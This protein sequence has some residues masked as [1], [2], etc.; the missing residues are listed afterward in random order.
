MLQIQALRQDPQSAKDRLAIKNFI[1]INLVDEIIALD[2]ERKNCNWN[3]IIHYPNLIA[4]QK[5]SGSSWQKERKKKPKQKK[6]KW[7][8]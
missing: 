5:R 3:Q 4:P 7:L 2:D 8:L 1:S 6:G